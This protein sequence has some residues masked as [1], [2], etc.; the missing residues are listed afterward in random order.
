VC[1]VVLV[2]VAT[3]ILALLGLEAGDE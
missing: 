3:M 1:A 2:A